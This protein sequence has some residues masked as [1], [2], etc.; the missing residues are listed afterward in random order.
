MRHEFSLLEIGKALNIPYGRLREWKDMGL[1]HSNAKE[2]AGQGSK[3]LFSREDA[4]HITLLANLIDSGFSRLHA[5]VQADVI[6][7]VK[8]DFAAVYTPITRNARAMNTRTGKID[9]KKRVVIAPA[10]V[11]AKALDL[12][13][14]APWDF[15]SIYNL[16][17]VR[18][19]V[20]MAL[21]QLV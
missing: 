5:A 14:K 13:K 1:I 18:E 21:D 20:N 9:R 11:E 4:Y 16:R 6:R 17:K 8:W 7:R 2:S 19:D 15:A 12:T 10:V 3:A